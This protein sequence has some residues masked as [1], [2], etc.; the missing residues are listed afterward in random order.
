M[1]SRLAL[2][3]G[4]NNA[5]VVSAATSAA[6]SNPRSVAKSPSL[7]NTLASTYRAAMGKPPVDPTREVVKS[8]LRIFASGNWEKLGEIKVVVATT[9]EQTNGDTNPKV[10]I[11]N[12]IIH[13][14]NDLGDLVKEVN[15]RVIPGTVEEI[16][17]LLE[18]F[19]GSKRVAAGSI[20]GL[21]GGIKTIVATNAKV[22]GL[23]DEAGAGITRFFEEKDAQYKAARTFIRQQARAATVAAAVTASKSQAAATAKQL[24]NPFDYEL[25]NAGWE[26]LKRKSQAQQQPVTK[27]H[28]NKALAELNKMT[29][30]NWAQGH[31]VGRQGGRKSRR[32]R[33]NKRRRNM[34]RRS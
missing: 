14:F 6:A 18:S 3:P 24:Q 26:E 21:K 30:A 2:V 34:T 15:D 9:L 10:V 8:I 4:N 11:Y 22:A 13:A 27:E 31:P 25:S 23:I 16:D 33:S 32:N 29:S 7:F 1:A 28:I 12:T 20:K 5:S 19:R 17:T